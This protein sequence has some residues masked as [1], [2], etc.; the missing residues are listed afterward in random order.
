MARLSSWGFFLVRICAILLFFS[1]VDVA[2]GIFYCLDRLPKARRI[3]QWLAYGFG[4]LQFVLELTSFAKYESFNTKYYN[5]LKNGGRYSTLPDPSEIRP[6]DLLSAAA[7][8]LFCV[9]YIAELGL[10]ILVITI[11][12]RG[13]EHHKVRGQ[14]FWGC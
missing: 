5:H 11:V 10:S 1:L 8:V 6:F 7:S 12:R 14:R 3:A 4:F 2:V 9:A 13:V